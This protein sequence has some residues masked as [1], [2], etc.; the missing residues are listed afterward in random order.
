M[1]TNEYI[2]ENYRTVIRYIDFAIKDKPSSGVF[3]ELKSEIIQELLEKDAMA[4]YDPSKGKVNTY[5][6]NRIRYACGHTLDRIQYTHRNIAPTYK[7]VTETG[8]RT[9]L[10]EKGNYITTPFTYERN[11]KGTN[12]HHSEYVSFHSEA[13]NDLIDENTTNLETSTLYK[14]I[15]AVLTEDEKTVLSLQLKGKTGKEIAF[16][17]GCTTSQIKTLMSRTKRKAS[18]LLCA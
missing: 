14:E 5:L 17:L 6:T 18:N 16:E 9:V 11:I 2:K 1:N 8:T 15:Q 4:S 13:Y 10:D 12:Q 3:S 7:K